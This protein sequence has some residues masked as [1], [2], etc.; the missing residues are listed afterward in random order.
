MSQRL[1][2][3][4]ALFSQNQGPGGGGAPTRRHFEQRSHRAQLIICFRAA[5]ALLAGLGCS[6]S[7]MGPRGKEHV[8]FSY[9][10]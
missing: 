7:R 8:G 3:L 9:I 10:L 6:H 5:R 2:C 1:W 4:S